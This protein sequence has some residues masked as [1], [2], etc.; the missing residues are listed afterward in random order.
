ML[1]LDDILNIFGKEKKINLSCKTPFKGLSIDTRTLKAGEIFL[2]LKGHRFD[3]HSF[4][5][6]AFKKGAVAA[7]VRLDKMASLLKKR[8]YALIGVDDTQVALE[9]IARV[10]RERFKGRV[11]AVTGSNGKTTTKEMIA[12]ILSSRFNVLKNTGTQNNHIGVPLTIFR[13]RDN[14][15][16]ITFELGANKR[17]EILSLKELTKPDFG[18]ITNVGQTHLEFLNTK[19]E[20]LATKLELFLDGPHRVKAA[21]LNFDDENLKKASSFLKCQVISF[22]KGK[23]CQYRAN[24]ITQDKERISFTINRRYKIN[25][26]TIGGHNVYNA[27]AAWALTSRLGIA[28]QVIQERLSTFI[29]PSHRLNVIKIKDLFVIDDTYNANPQS[30]KAAFKALS[31]FK[32]VQKRIACVADMLE[33]G[34]ASERLHYEI[35]FEAARLGIDIVVAFGQFSE[36]LHRGVLKGGGTNCVIKETKSEVL[37]WLLEN[38]KPKQAI[39]FKGSRAMKMEELVRCFIDSYTN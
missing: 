39:L 6:E 20:V 23:D 18:L 31:S 5:D 10:M 28:P 1:K 25:L 12:H 14:H 2:A 36:F 21:F 22:G 29:F 38:I 11:I 24:N 27:L 8:S 13:L 3:G 37:K 19:E 16:L 9:K 32:G 35:G 17:G 15:Q 30:V 33:L 4:L 34:E 26:N 7:I